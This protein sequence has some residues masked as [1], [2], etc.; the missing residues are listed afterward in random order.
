[1]SVGRIR[2]VSVFL[3]NIRG[4]GA[5]VLCNLKPAATVALTVTGF[6]PFQPMGS[7][8]YT[9]YLPMGKG[10][11]GTVLHY[12][13]AIVSLFRKQRIVACTRTPRFQPSQLFS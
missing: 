10:D 13:A 12:H 1:M 9:R 4:I 5:R 6:H 3:R 8:L 7:N 2:N 11:T